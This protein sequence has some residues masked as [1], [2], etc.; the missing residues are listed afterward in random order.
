MFWNSGSGAV[1]SRWIDTDRALLQSYGVR[2]RVIAIPGLLSSYIRRYSWTL[3]YDLPSVAEDSVNHTTPPENSSWSSRCREQH[4]AITFWPA[5]INRRDNSKSLAPLVLHLN[6]L[7]LCRRHKCDC[8]QKLGDISKWVW[9]EKE[10]L[11]FF[12]FF[13]LNENVRKAT[14]NVWCSCLI[15]KKNKIKCFLFL[16][17]HIH[18]NIP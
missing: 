13:L 4:A 14:D 3:W 11:I 2:D 1:W 10:R 9:K 12:F 18:F 7:A 17:H 16:S 8:W 5:L 6:R 15:K